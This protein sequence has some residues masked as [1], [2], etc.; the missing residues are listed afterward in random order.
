M[1]VGD[2]W[3]LPSAKMQMKVRLCALTS[4]AALTGRL[5]WL[6]ATSFRRLFGSC[7]WI[8]SDF[9][10][11]FLTQKTLLFNNWFMVTTGHF[12]GSFSTAVHFYLLCWICFEPGECWC[13]I[14][15]VLG[16]L[17]TL[18]SVKEILHT[19]IVVHLFLV[20]RSFVGNQK[21]TELV[22]SVGLK[23]WCLFLLRQ[24]EWTEFGCLNGF[25]SDHH[26]PI[27]YLGCSFSWQLSHTSGPRKK[28]W[29]RY[30]P[31]VVPQW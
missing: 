4:L 1:T 21:R 19:P 20:K 6:V 14:W 23:D 25:C 24:E 30:R 31:Q 27:T 18:N 22:S 5:W 11:F 9:T 7:S 26:F 17:W 28:L 8:R 29:M 12:S 16:S 15:F 3:G 10:L 13:S 2:I